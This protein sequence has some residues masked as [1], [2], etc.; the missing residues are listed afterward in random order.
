MNDRNGVT[1]VGSVHSDLIATASVMPALGSS[2]VGTQFTLAPGGKAGNQATQ[3]SRL[4]IHTWL[5]SSVG[6]DPLGDVISD[7]LAAANV[8]RSFLVRSTVAPTGASTIFAVDGEYASIIVPGAAGTLREED[9]AAAAP[10]FQQSRFA[11]TQLEL[12]PDLAFAALRHAQNAGAVA[13]LNASPL[14]GLDIDSLAPVLKSTDILIVNR[15]EAEL[16]LARSSAA[17]GGATELAHRLRHLFG[18]QVVV[19]TCGA[20]GAVLVRDEVEFNQPAFAIQVADSIGAGD[21][22]LGALIAS[23]VGSADDRSALK[24]ASAAGALAASGAGAHASL[25]DRPM[26]G[27][28]L[29]E[30]D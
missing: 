25:P 6:A 4:G 12:G 17:S 2:V 27:A 5:V 7:Q 8:D 26:L 9:L 13:V 16:L 29:R 3:V 18:L 15:H 10:A 20:E 30:R 11:V 1:V 19:I 23:W 22:F 28:F 21:A 24:A 14:V